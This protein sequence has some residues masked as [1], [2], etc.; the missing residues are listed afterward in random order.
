MGKLPLDLSVQQNAEGGGARSKHV[1]SQQN[2]ASLLGQ[3]NLTLL[4]QLHITNQIGGFMQNGPTHNGPTRHCK[5][6]PKCETRP[7]K[8]DRFGNHDCRHSLHI[9]SKPNRA[10]CLP[11]LCHR[12][13]EDV[14]PSSISPLADLPTAS[15]QHV[16]LCRRPAR[17]I[18]GCVFE[19]TLFSLV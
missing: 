17:F 16:L 4:T 18:C 13:E 3:T 11:C 14:D 12:Y 2:G 7:S 15:Q 9:R 1:S 10:C 6:A 5:Q 19:A 8:R